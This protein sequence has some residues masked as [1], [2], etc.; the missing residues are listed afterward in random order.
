MTTTM[1]TI[2]GGPRA[3]GTAPA[4][5]GM[6]APVAEAVKPGSLLRFGAVAFQLALLVGAIRTLNI[7]NVGFERV[8]MLLLGAFV[9]HHFLPAT[10]RM[11][12]FA[13]VSVVSVALIFRGPAA[14]WFYGL[15]LA[16]IA[17]CHLPVSFRWRIVAVAA[18]GAAFAARRANWEPLIGI[19]VPGAIWPILGSMFM[20]RVVCYLYDMKHKSAPFSL[21]R[22][23]AY[24]FMLPNI[25][26][27]LFPV[28][29]YKTF[30]RNHYNDDPIRIYQVG[31]RW[32]LRG[33]VQLLIYRT[34]Y[35]RWMVAPGDV[36]SAGG[37]AQYMLTTFLLYLK[38]SGM[39]HLIV[40]MLHMFGFNLPETHHN[41]LLSSSFTDFWRR[42]NIYWKDFIQKLVFFPLYF[43]LKKLGEA[44][45]LAIAT[46]LAF[47]VTWLLHS[48]QWFWIR[49]TF[50]ITWHDG[51]FWMGLGV[52][53]VINTR[54]EQRR[55]RR[56]TLKTAKRSLKTGVLTAL[57][58][59]GTFTSI[60]ILWTIWSTPSTA[61]LKIIF[62]SL[63]KPTAKEA[64]VILAVPAAIGVAAVFLGTKAR[65][66][67]E[68]KRAAA[69]APFAFWRHATIVGAC[70]AALFVVGWRPALLSPVS[71]KAKAF[72]VKLKENRLNTRDEARLER[73]YYEDLGDVTRFNSEL[74]AAF[75]G[76]PRGW[77]VNPAVKQIQSPLIYELA[78]SFHGRFKDANFGTNALGLRDK[79]YTLEKPEGVL[80]IA[81]IGSSH[82]MGAGVND[83]ETYE[84]VAEEML[85]NEGGLGGRPVEI[86][87]YSIGGL[88]PFQR[89]VMLEQKALL[90]KP[91]VAIYVAH[92]GELDWTTRQYASLLSRVGTAPYEYMREAIAKA[93]VVATDSQDDVDRKL[94]SS[95]AGLARGG[96]DEFARIA[97]EAGVKPVVCLLMIPKD[98]KG[99]PQSIL[100]LAAHAESIGVPVM[101]L[102]GSFDS[103]KNRKSLHINSFDNHT[104]PTGH[105]MLAE[106]FVAEF[107]RV[108]SSGDASPET[109]KPASPGATP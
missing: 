37:A 42:I 74:W 11:A 84:S 62:T 44:S 70:A 85:S 14:V 35:Q 68:G 58:T 53:V 97:R 90:A 78:P 12:F 103:V 106:R 100:D 61:E 57:T 46:I 2:S 27:T 73:G 94:H 3:P 67:T 45:G 33:V 87:N 47:L 109:P 17:A 51:I 43:R 107:R 23:L 108:M 7:E 1:S 8:S 80:R 30:C 96:I 49:E 25:S 98:T 50:P 75:G 63:L 65:E 69:T 48:Y 29:D 5:K 36:V 10:M 18:V 92:S 72:V 101:S 102:W 91:D 95:Q 9:V 13:L 105:R 54:W 31:L 41:Y 40:G 6:A 16:L 89:V 26:F 77:S 79:E 83:G 82:D 20:F 88:S 71:T 104:N 4:P 81:L 38:L 34:V 21:D 86:L 15:A 93:G 19:K 22:A 76:R 55:G 52:L 60:C 99:P 32:I 64:L 28:V 66:H 24:F 59:A 39:F 56:R